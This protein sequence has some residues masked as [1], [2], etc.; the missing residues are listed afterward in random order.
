[1]I[2]C[3]PG[4][5][6]V[7]LFVYHYASFTVSA[8]TMAALTIE[9]MIVVFSPFQYHA[10]ENKKAIAIS[11]IISIILISFIIYLPMVF[12][13]TELYWNTLTGNFDLNGTYP[14][15]SLSIAMLSAFAVI[16]PANIALI[17][18][19]HKDHKFKR[20]LIIFKINV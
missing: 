9:R 19:L 7:V 10:Q 5:P 1:M 14:T 18:K 13:D 4:D 11:V 12:K 6:Y 17:V 8:F 3:D 2:K 16:F 15:W 20:Y